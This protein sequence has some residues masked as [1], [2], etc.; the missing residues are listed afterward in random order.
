MATIL[1]APLKLAAS[2][3]NQNAIYPAGNLALDYPSMVWRS[4]NLSAVYCRFEIL[5]GSW[6]TVCLY[7]TN[8]RPSDTVRIRAGSSATGTTSSPSFD[9]GN[10]PAF[11]GQASANS[12]M[13][14]IDVG[15]LR[16]ERF[17]RI[18]ISSSGNPSGYVEASRLIIGQ[19]VEEQG[20]DWGAEQSFED[21]SEVS[22]YRGFS[23]VDAYPTKAAW[24]FSITGITPQQYATN[25]VP[26]LRANGTKSGVLFVPDT[27]SEFVQDEAVFGRMITAG[28]GQAVSSS[29]YKVDL[30]IKEI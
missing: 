24:K 13:V 6:D 25:W 20:V 26:L 14:L 21:P 23:T 11:S 22:E 10:R 5:A 15:S 19:K 4:S 3:A 17:V 18:D 9:S 27:D 8:L 2:A 29:E 30:T 7:G 16:T 1:C 12:N 28:K